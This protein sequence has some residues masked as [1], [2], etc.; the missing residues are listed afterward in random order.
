MTSDT[1][2]TRSDSPMNAETIMRF[3]FIFSCVSFKKRFDIVPISSSSHRVEYAS[4]SAQASLGSD[5]I[6]VEILKLQAQY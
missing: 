1:K 4:T 6:G 2:L 3:C 5:D